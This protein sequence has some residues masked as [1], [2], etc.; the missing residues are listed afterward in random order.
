MNEIVTEVLGR[1]IACRWIPLDDGLQL[2]LT[3]GDRSHIGAVS[4]AEPDGTVQT[5][6]FPGHR[7]Q[8]LSAPWAR[9]LAQR[10]GCRVCVICGIHYDDLAREDLQTVLAAADALLEAILQRLG[11]QA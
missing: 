7:D 4:T 3:G 9:T 10:L 11:A 8:E 2:L 1:Q 5:Q 6:T